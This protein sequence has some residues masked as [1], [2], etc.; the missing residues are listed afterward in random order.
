MQQEEKRAAR[1]IPMNARVRIRAS[2]SAGNGIAC[3]IRDSSP[4]G[5]C[6]V[7]DSVI[8]SDWSWVDILTCSGE[9]LREP[10]RARIVRIDPEPGGGQKLGCSF[11]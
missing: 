10:I 6:L 4:A 8:E 11:E 3:R 1:R 5:I 9:P 7:P 2:G